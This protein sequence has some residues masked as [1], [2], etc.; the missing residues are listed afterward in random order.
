LTAFLKFVLGAGFLALFGLPV[1]DLWKLLVLLAAWLALAC[2]DLRLARRRITAAT[3]LGL[4]VILVRHAL[5]GAAIEEAHNIFL[6]TGEDD[7]LRRGL[8]PV[9]YEKWRQRFERQYP[10]HSDPGAPWRT[11]LPVT[12]YALSSD[13]LWRPAR[14]SRTVDAIAFENLSE[15]RGGFTNEAAYGFY[16]G[17][18]ISLTR[19]FRADLPFFVMYE[20]SRASAGCILNWRGTVFWERADGSFEEIT[21]VD[22]AGRTIDEAD[23]G[24]RVYALHVPSAVGARPWEWPRNTA[25]TPSA[26]ELAIRLQLRAALAGARIAGGLVSAGGVFAILLLLTTIRWRSYFTALGITAVS[27]AIVAAVIHFSVGKYLGST[28]PPHGGG[29]D[30]ITHESMGRAM[31]RAM[32]SGD[33]KEALRGGQ[34][35]YWDTPGMRYLRFVEKIIFGDT[36][37]GYTALVVL[38]PWF[39]YL[40]VQ[41]IAGKRWAIA[42]VAIFLLSPL[43]S[44]SFVQYI[45]NAKLG[46][47]EAAG[48]GFLVLGLS[49]LTSSQPRWG[50]ERNPALAFFGGVSLAGAMF[51]RPNLAIA[52]PVAGSL[53]VL[54][55]WRSRDYTTV[56]AAMAGLACALWMPFHNYVYGHQFVLISASA[57]ALTVPLTPMTYLRALQEVATGT[58]DGEYLGRVAKQLLGWL[59]AQPR[60][61]TQALAV[62]T[63]PFLILR[64]VTLAM[65]LFAAVC[66]RQGGALAAVAWVALAAH[67]PMLFIFASAQFRYAMT[68]WDLT[69]IVTLLL[70]ADQVRRRRGIPRSSRVQPV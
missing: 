59:Q 40:L 6:V 67:L 46:Y 50:G 4:T 53:F 58:L 5:P 23:V 48:F 27:L 31:A 60:L 1:L 43:G 69:A 12:P 45:Q 9:I 20:F 33:W 8:P 14:Y 38:L 39:L 15:F 49:V 52:V 64:L 66:A 54:A 56:A 26:S 44:L 19:G 7:V 32:M 24:K 35:V 70:M 68:A 41:R 57:S 61:P 62:L 65:T 37:L 63:G 36:N 29:D 25:A 34:D 22:K 17:D 42:T 11:A 21:H 47:A 51:I 2:S 18:A 10:P 28:Y 30:G 13:A 55:S 3:A 16:G